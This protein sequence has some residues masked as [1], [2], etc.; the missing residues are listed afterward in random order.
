MGK[1]ENS[2]RMSIESKL[3][4]RTPSVL[5]DLYDFT[6]EDYLS[7]RDGTATDGVEVTA[8]GTGRLSG[9]TYTVPAH[10]V[11]TVEFMMRINCVTP[12]DVRNMSALIRS[13]LDA[14]K[15]TLFD[16]YSKTDV[17]GG[18]SFFGFFSLGVRANY[19][20]TKRRMESWGLSEE[21]QVTIVNAM[22]QIA[23]K[24][25]D[26]KYS[27]TIYNRDYDYAVSGNMMAIVMDCTIKT[28]T[29]QIQHRYLAPNA[30]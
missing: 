21:N 7:F 18:A 19:T 25:S 27:G 10:G 17:S 22:T 23:N 13:L 26:Y 24:T 16:D 15:K 28:A 5:P 1:L 20:Q 11:I 14:S 4:F 30:H 9:V 2:K 6:S 12:E 3:P 29:T 8:Y